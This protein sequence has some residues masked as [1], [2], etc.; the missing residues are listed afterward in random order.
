MKLNL[1]GTQEK[2][3]LQ[4]H[5][6]NNGDNIYRILPPIEGSN[7]SP[8]KRW[9]I[10]WLEIDG[11]PKPVPSPRSFSEK[12]CPVYNFCDELDKK[13]KEELKPLLY[14][15]SIPEEE[16]ARIDKVINEIIPA[17]SYN[18]KPKSSF[19]YN[20]IN[21]SGVVGCLEVKKTANDQLIGLM[22]EYISN[23][24]Q[25]P[26]SLDSTDDDCGVWFNFVRE[27][28]GRDTTYRVKKVETQIRT[29]KTITIEVDRTP[30]PSNVVDNYESLAIDIFNLYKKLSNE[31]I[32]KLII[33]YVVQKFEEYTDLLETN[34]FKFTLSDEKEEKEVNK[35]IKKTKPSVNLKLN[36]DSDFD[37][38]DDDILS[39]ADK[40][41]NK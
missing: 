29:G 6:I 5:K 26:T 17:I 22:R 33:T 14:D 7:G 21:K 13:S 8:F 34:N 1:D 35:P 18:I 2:K 39:F 27:G 40:A 12:E 20:A 41:L 32:K 9:Q 16:K 31:E 30:L 23:F 25:D 19:Y 36:Q 38:D 10:C 11:K 4:K 24:N 37:D 15:K 3:Q 28:V